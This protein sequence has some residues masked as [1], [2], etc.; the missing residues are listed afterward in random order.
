MKS[1]DQIKFSLRQFTG[2]STF[3]KFSPLFPNVVL[4]EGAEYLADEC[5][6]Y[7]LMDMI[8][9]HIPSVPKDETFTIAQLTVN[10]M[11]KA[12]FTL[13]DDSPATKIYANQ[14]ISYTD[15]PL[16]EVKLYVIREGDEWVILLTSEY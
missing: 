13:A 4:T 2:S 3:T 1:Q 14:S 16:D 5:G 12:F 8:A 15:F 7:W 11:N 9:S 6:A 10:P